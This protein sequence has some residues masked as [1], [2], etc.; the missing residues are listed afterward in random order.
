MENRE[1]RQR[2]VARIRRDIGLSER[3]TWW[4]TALI[5]KNR[6]EVIVFERLSSG[7]KYVLCVFVRVYADEPYQR[8]TRPSPI[9]TKT[10]TTPW[11]AHGSDGAVKP[12]AIRHL[13]PDDSP[14]DIGLVIP[15]PHKLYSPLVCI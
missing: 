6:R 1:E 15:L 2:T 7:P 12:G 4:T 14:I 11:L 8:A 13:S 5:V 9:G 10:S 3:R